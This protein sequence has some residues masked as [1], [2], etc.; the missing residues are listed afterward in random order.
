[1]RVFYLDEPL[2]EEDLELLIRA[3]TER[4]GVPHPI[5]QIKL[6]TVLPTPDSTTG[7]FTEPPEGREALVG[8][9]L[10]RAGLAQD[11]GLQVGWVMPKDPSWGAI[12]QLAIHRIT[13]VYPMV[14]QRWAP[15]EQGAIGRRNTRVID[16]HGIMADL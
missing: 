6:A 16:V 7:L 12:F 14:V 11:K 15:D 8:Q 3:A 10:E 9:Q 1:M 5:E 13:G 2:D 4:G